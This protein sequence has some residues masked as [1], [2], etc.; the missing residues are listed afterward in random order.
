[1]A[2]GGCAAAIRR[3]V[4]PESASHAPRHLLSRLSDFGEHLFAL[5]QEAFVTVHHFFDEVEAGHTA[6]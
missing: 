4:S 1:M 2:D 5:H 3:P 6:C